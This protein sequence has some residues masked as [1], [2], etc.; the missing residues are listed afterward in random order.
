MAEFWRRWLIIAAAITGLAGL[1]FAALAAMGASQIYN[2]IFDLVFLPG[3]LDAP[4]RDAAS[5]AMGVMGAVLVGW[6]ATMLVLLA[7]PSVSALPE[8][9]RAVTAGLVVWFVVDG[10]VSIAAG[11]FGNLVLN[12]GFVVLFA[13]PLVATRPGAGSGTAAMTPHTPT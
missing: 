11:A 6:A 8:T 3:E 10:I 9:W 5:F 1:G 12:V 7:S 2:T 4:A 13:P